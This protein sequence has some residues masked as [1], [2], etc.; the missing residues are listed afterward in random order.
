MDFLKSFDCFVFDLDGVVYSGDSA[1]ADSPKVFETLRKN[2]KGIRFLTNNPSKFP[3]E[4]VAKLSKFGINSRAGEFVTS[5][6]ATAL[7]IREKLPAEK[8]KTVFTAGSPHLKE[9]V[10]KVGLVEAE[11]E[12]ARSADLVV[13][14]SHSGFCLEEIKTACAAVG[15]G[16]GFIGTNGDRFY[17]TENGRAPATG[18]LL[19]SVETASGK[20]A[21]LAGKP[22]RYMFDL[23]EETGAGPAN[24]TL[25]VG[26]S[27]GAD[28]AGGKNAGYATALVMTGVTM[29]KDLEDAPAKPDFILKDVS[30]LLDRNGK[31]SA[32]KAGTLS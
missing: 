16:A 17:P 2:G 3:S 12:T 1:L 14:G 32:T 27:L 23:L 28:I 4:F 31:T 25:L 30:F 22:Q 8:W 26:D 10:K 15:N 21:I 19:A 11:G 24:G 29:E 13:M 6:M 7:L 18:S 5:P 9:E 20:K